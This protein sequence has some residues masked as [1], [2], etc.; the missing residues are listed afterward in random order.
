MSD[1]WYE[2]MEIAKM[3]DEAIRN[4]MHNIRFSLELK[5][6]HKSRGFSIY[7]LENLGKAFSSIGNS[8]QSHY[9]YGS[10]KHMRKVS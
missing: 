9:H 10:E 5:K 2:I 3:R 6:A 8:L 4:D 1:N 7:L